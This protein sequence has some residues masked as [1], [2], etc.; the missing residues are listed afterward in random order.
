MFLW[1][2]SP[3][4]PAPKQ[5]IHHA[6]SWQLSRVSQHRPTSR[7]ND[8]AKH[9]KA[10][11]NQETRQPTLLVKTMAWFLFVVPGLPN[12]LVHVIFLAEVTISHIQGMFKPMLTFLKFT[13][14][15]N[16]D[17]TS[18]NE[19]N[20]DVFGLRIL[21]NDWIVNAPQRSTWFL[22]R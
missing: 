11:E 7:C 6:K 8:G 9:S 2:S 17:L 1:I 12:V 3:I 18:F 21:W 10:A 16:N 19:E 20:G 22:R 14:C 15:Q 5:W 4:G 13:L